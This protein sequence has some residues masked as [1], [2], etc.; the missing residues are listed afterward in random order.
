MPAKENKEVLELLYPVPLVM[1]SLL[2]ISLLTR[3]HTQHAHTIS[4]LRSL[5]AGILLC[6]IGTI[7][8]VFQEVREEVSE[9]S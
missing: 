4:S 3:I 8:V 6:G 9:K 2:L 1:V 5:S 7:T